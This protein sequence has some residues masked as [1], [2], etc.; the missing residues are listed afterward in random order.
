MTVYGD[1]TPRTAA[2]A[3][4]KMLERAQPSLNMAKFAV[5]TAVPKG[6]TKVVKWRRYG[7]LA[8]TTTPLTE[9][10]TPPCISRVAVSSISRRVRA[11]G[12]RIV[13]SFTMAC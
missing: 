11:R 3:V 5:V 4:D 6:K 12:P 9:G 8:P 10:V 13:S 7:R 1:I 2:Y